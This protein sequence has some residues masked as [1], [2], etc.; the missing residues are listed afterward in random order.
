MRQGSEHYLPLQGLKDY[1]LVHVPKNADATAKGDTFFSLILWMFRYIRKNHDM[2]DE[3][4]VV[5]VVGSRGVA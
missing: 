1:S 4:T 2:A 5:I 3:D